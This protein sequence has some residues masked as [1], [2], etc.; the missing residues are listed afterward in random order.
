MPAP[1]ITLATRGYDGMVPILRGEVTMPGVEIRPV[2]DDNVARIF[3]RLYTGE[4]DAGEMSL[5]ELVYYASREEAPFVA[6]P[7]F[8]SRVFR[9]G[10]LFCHT[11]AGI[12]GPS[13]LNGRRIGVQ[14]WV[15]TA[16]VW[17]RGM[18]AEDYGVD[19]R[20]AQWLVAA[21]H[22]WDHETGE[23]IRPR[24]GSILQPLR[25]AGVSGAADAHR[26]LIAGAVD[27]M[28]VTEVQS[29]QLL[30]DPRVRRMFADYRAEEVAYYRRTGIFPIMHVLAM[31]RSV[32]DTH[33]ELP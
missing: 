17:V 14:R 16:G 4:V 28:G 9:H 29:P 1:V 24:D 8:P 27:A 21:T 15:Q 6:I 20:G 10:F 19:P 30:A 12:R 18:L 25:L 2:V 13:D 11:Q 33:P 5:A 26:A 31:R 22:H 3:G 32:V 23:E 7:V